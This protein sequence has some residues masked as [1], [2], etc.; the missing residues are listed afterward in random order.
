MKEQPV[1]TGL[2]TVPE[3]NPDLLHL[4]HALKFLLHRHKRNATSRIVKRKYVIFISVGYIF[5]FTYCKFL[6]ETNLT[7]ELSNVDYMRWGFFSLTKLISLIIKCHW[8]WNF[9]IR[10]RF[11]LSYK[12]SKVKKKRPKMITWKT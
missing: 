8:K 10:L 5:F 3:S 11:I 7:L 1:V 4:K 12:P 2:N 6:L 9:N